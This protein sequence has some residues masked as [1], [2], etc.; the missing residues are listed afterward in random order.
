MAMVS[1]KEIHEWIFPENQRK[2][3][4][5]KQNPR[6]QK[7][8]KKRSCLVARLSDRDH[9]VTGEGSFGLPREERNGLRLGGWL[10]SAR[11]SHLAKEKVG[12]SSGLDRSS[13]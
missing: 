8:K 2:P 1:L 3:V 10:G 4:R 7:M 12:M 11:G 6:K 13:V 9:L 5:H